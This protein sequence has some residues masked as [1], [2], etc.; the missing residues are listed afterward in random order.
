MT[1]ESQSLGNA[2]FFGVLYKGFMGVRVYD[3]KAWEMFWGFYKGFIGFRVYESHS[4]GNADFFGVSGLGFQLYADFLGF[5]KGLQ[6]LGFI[7][8]RA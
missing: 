3:S 4:L 5:Y 6:D 1:R 2:D 8:L 7:G